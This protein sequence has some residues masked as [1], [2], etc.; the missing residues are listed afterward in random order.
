MPVRLL[1]DIVR[2]ELG[3]KILTKFFPKIDDPSNP[4]GNVEKI[5][6]FVDSALQWLGDTVP[7]TIE[8]TST[9]VIPADGKI[10]LSVD[11]GDKVRKFIRVIQNGNVHPE[12]VQDWSEGTPGFVGSWIVKDR[13][14]YAIAITTRIRIPGFLPFHN[15]HR[16]RTGR[17]LLDV[18]P[19]EVVYNGI[20]TRTQIDNN[21]QFRSAVVDYCA[22][23]A[24]EYMVTQILRPKIV[25]IEGV[26]EIT[27]NASRYERLGNLRKKSAMSKLDSTYADGN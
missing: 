18:G 6:E 19:I 24:Y 14:F 3:R 23:L 21:A 15:F 13:I 8:D 9:F 22:Y 5:A 27:D 16:Y 26:P 4:E 20:P 25:V 12:V 2:E 10:S 11:P 7:V 1:D 17:F